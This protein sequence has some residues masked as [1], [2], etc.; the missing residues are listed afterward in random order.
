MTLNMRPQA[1]AIDPTDVSL[2]LSVDPVLFTLIADR[3][4]VLLRKRTWPPFEGVWALPGAINPPREQ[5]KDTML[6]ELASLGLG[7]IWVEQLKTFDRPPQYV[8][9]AL[10]VPGRDPRGRVISVAYFGLVPIGR[11]LAVDDENVR[12]MPVNHLPPLAFDHAEIVQ[13]ALWRLRN[14]ILY[15]S[16]AFQ[17]LPPE[18]T[19]TQLQRAYEHVLS[20]ALDKRNFRRK[21]LEAGVVEDTGRCTRQGTRRPARLY[22]FS[23]LDFEFR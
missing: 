2:R 20:E 6:A 19:L 12:W 8:D 17:L 11:E 22:R 4:H 18:F 14:K 10:T 5:L 7:D 3:L 1:E 16:V 23:H 9:G 21:V 15:S 13:Y